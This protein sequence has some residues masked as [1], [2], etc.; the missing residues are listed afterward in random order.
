MTWRAGVQ[1]LLPLDWEEQPSPAEAALARTMLVLGLTSLV[2]AGGWMGLFMSHHD[3]HSIWEG[4]RAFSQGGNPY[5]RYQEYAT[6][7]AETYRGDHKLNM[8]PPLVVL[9]SVPLGS[10]EYTT[11]KLVWWGLNLGWAF[12]ALLACLWFC[13]DRLSK[14][15]AGAVVLLFG[16]FYPALSSIYFGNYDNLIAAL[17]ALTYVGYRKGLP[18]LGGTALA[19]GV[20]LKGFPGFL[21]LY[22]AWKRQWKLLGVSAIVGV[23]LFAVTLTGMSFE[24]QMW[25]FQAASEGLPRSHAAAVNQTLNAWSLRLF[26]YDEIFSQ[27]I[28][29]APALAD[30]VTLVMQVLLLVGLLAVTFRNTDPNGPREQLCFCLAL[31]TLFIIP[32]FSNTKHFILAVLPVAVFLRLA[33]EGAIGSRILTIAMVAHG[34]LAFYIPVYTSRVYDAG[35]YGRLM[36]GWPV[37][38]LSEGLYAILALWGCCWWYLWTHTAEE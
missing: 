30:G 10:L 7:T 8:Y 12:L 23:G 26:T 2:V 14:V 35:V 24:R 38:F 20:L 37:L 28:V 27:G 19:L 36:V 16:T 18:A 4:V 1:A 32:P 33:M 25:W 3:F 21:G 6:M 17:M 5:F 22:F 29:N 13:G 15:E 9:L 34:V 11:A 31:L